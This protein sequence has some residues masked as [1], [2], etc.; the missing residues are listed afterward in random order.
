MNVLKA[1]G[2]TGRVSEEPSKSKKL[3]YAPIM[4]LPGDGR[5]TD[6][7]HY[8]GTITICN[9]PEKEGAIMQTRERKAGK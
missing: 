6:E 3:K 1:A 4:T 9:L 8:E 2:R 5:R 7:K